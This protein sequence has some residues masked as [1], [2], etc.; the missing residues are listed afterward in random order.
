MASQPPP[1][2]TPADPSRPGPSRR[3]A[4]PRPRRAAAAPRRRAAAQRNKERIVLQR[5]MDLLRAGVNLER[6]DQFMEAVALKTESLQE[7]MPDFATELRHLH[8]FC[9]L[10]RHG[11]GNTSPNP[12]EIADALQFFRVPTA[13]LHMALSV[14]PC[15][16]ALKTRALTFL[17]AWESDNMHRAQ[18]TKCLG[19]LLNCGPAPDTVSEFKDFVMHLAAQY[20]ALAT[21]LGN[22]SPEL[23]AED[24]VHAEIL[25]AEGV[26]DQLTKSALNRAAEHFWKEL[27]S[28]SGRTAAHDDENKANTTEIERTWDMVDMMRKSVDLRGAFEMLLGKEHLSKYT[29]HLEMQHQLFL[30]WTAVF[31]KPAS[32]VNIADAQTLA[33][34][35]QCKTIAAQCEAAC[36][37][38]SAPAA[39]ATAIPAVA[40]PPGPGPDPD[41]G[42]EAAACR[43]NEAPVASP[44]PS[45]PAAA[46]TAIPAVASPPGPGPDPDGGGEAAVASPPAAAA[47]APRAPEEEDA[48]APRAPEQEEEEAA[49]AAAAAARRLRRR[50][51]QCRWRRQTAVAVTRTRRRQCRWQSQTAAA[52]TTKTKT[53][54]ERRLRRPPQ[55]RPE[56]RK[57]R[58]QAPMVRWQA[59]T[60]TI[61][62]STVHAPGLQH[63]RCVTRSSGIWQR[64]QVFKR[65]KFWAKLTCRR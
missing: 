38:P 58:W 37:A 63:T 49:A 10:C 15:G 36:R 3:R 64:P 5:L 35:R 18:L 62:A 14:L 21:V 48:A 11:T 13:K 57:L 39:A 47:P 2:P 46:A 19:E 6:V 54:Q 34:A 24:D 50:R 65:V 27:E 30:T 61:V 26:V 60:M 29:E 55:R 25:E 12:R 42:G 51:R 33:A 31:K 32:S 53:K 59:P 56:P 45:A 41:G 7:S 28:E 52:R 17:E 1:G 44:A 16:Q 8:A 9:R 43:A 4:A 40:S 23:K 20:S 22:A